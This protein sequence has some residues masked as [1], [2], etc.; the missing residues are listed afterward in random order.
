LSEVLKCD[1]LLAYDWLRNRTTDQSL[2]IF[3]YQSVRGD[4]IKAAVSVLDVNARRRILRQVPATF[5]V[6]ELI[7]RLIGDNLTLYQEL[8]RDKR[9]KDFHLVPLL[10][11]PEGIWIE[12]AKLALD[13]GYRIEEVAE[14]VYG[15]S[16]A[17]MWSG[18]ESALWAEW[19]EKFDRLCLHE[20][21]CIRKVGE[22]GRAKAAAS[23]DRALEQERLEA[24]YGIDRYW[25][26]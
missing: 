19:V 14:A 5:G 1:P 7:K 16:V 8:L 26:A 9:L 25:G 11:D 17:R 6:A 10:G 12:K 15:Y 18:D 20:D 4:A 21:A 2:E 22:V 23:R 3:T 24:I 13:M